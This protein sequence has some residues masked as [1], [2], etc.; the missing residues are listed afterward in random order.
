[1]DLERTKKL[2][3]LH[4]S[5]QQ[6]AYNDRTGKPLCPQGDARV[7]I[8]VGR[9]IDVRGGPGL[10]ESEIQFMLANDLEEGEHL[11]SRTFP[12]F[13]ALSDVRRA[14]LIDM[15]HN[16]GMQRLKRFEQTLASVAAGNYRKA[17]LQMTQSR[18]ARQVGSRAQRLAEMMQSNE[19]PQEVG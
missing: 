6:F 15:H 2:I 17:S 10:R 4:E 8:G 13:D 7:T 3:I 11:L 18:W 12:W 9:N 14:V 5:S 16:L 1:M 19:W